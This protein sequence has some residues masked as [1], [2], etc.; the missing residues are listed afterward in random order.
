[1]DFVHYQ[2][3]VERPKKPVP[4]TTL[5]GDTVTI[6]A[7]QL[8]TNVGFSLEPSGIMTPIESKEVGSAGEIDEGEMSTR[9]R[10][11]QEQVNLLEKYFQMHPKPNTDVKRQLA[12][13]TDLALQ[14]VANWFQNRRAKAKH[15]KRQE[16]Y[17]ASRNHEAAGR[18]LYIE[19]LSPD[20][21]VPPGFFSHDLEVDEMHELSPADASMGPPS[22]HVTKPSFDSMSF[23]NF[24]DTS[25]DSLNRSWAA[26][27]AAT[28]MTQ[29][30]CGGRFNYNTAEVP[31]NDTFP[32]VSG[33]GN[34]QHD[35][36]VAS[37][38]SDWDSSKESS[39][40]WTPALQRDNPFDSV[41]THIVD[42]SRN[43]PPIQETPLHGEDIN[44]FALPTQQ[45][46]P[47]Q[48][49][50]HQQQQ[51]QQS[52]SLT[53]SPPETEIELP[54]LAPEA[55]TRRGSCPAD[56]VNDFSAVDIHS[57]EHQNSP[58][59]S[60][61]SLTIA[62]RRKKSRPAALANNALRSHSY[63]STLQVSPTA[64]T[65]FLGPASPVRRIRST[66]NNIDLYRGRIQKGTPGSAQR[67]PLSFAT[68]AEAG[69]FAEADSQN[70]HRNF[71]SPSQPS[72]GSAG[73]AP[74]TPL[75]P[76]D[77]HRG[78]SDRHEGFE[79]GP[80]DCQALSLKLADQSYFVPQP[81]D[82]PTSLASPPTTPH[83]MG[84][85]PYQQHLGLGDY[86]PAQS[87][88]HFYF[89]A[90]NFDEPLISPQYSAFPP[91]IHMPQPVYVSPISCGDPEMVQFFNHNEPAQVNVE[92][93][94][95][96]SSGGAVTLPEFH[97]QNTTP[98]H[99]PAP[100]PSGQTVQPKKKNYIFNNSTPNDY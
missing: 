81:Y 10:L 61:T 66:G 49:T 41:F 82:M 19:P 33:P 48:I 99:Q 37:A 63:M 62:A 60:E 22:S 80:S 16:Q 58:N 90:E 3:P 64:K 79:C 86:S 71:S 100:S 32:N 74:P 56:F 75:S 42:F 31:A 97:I 91:Q 29:D 93:P 45:L 4:D 47:S 39:V 13:S 25:C 12:E 65:S 70:A 67:S 35:S 21:L 87:G 95:Q 2:A 36:F 43:Q 98:P 28:A 68:F 44:M 46:F 76:V 89:Q 30:L 34:I 23:D 83:D 50:Q 26:T 54:M 15:Q 51:P 52:S 77:L 85:H 94:T 78:Q 73:L 1:M 11:T 92:R 96:E 40:T 9:P 14:R 27:A 53:S 57:E 17:E 88:E 18:S 20:F 38:F 7:C 24:P 59:S 69:A 84:M 5:R 8:S 6:S 55:L 72:S